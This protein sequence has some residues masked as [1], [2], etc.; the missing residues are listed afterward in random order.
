[1]GYGRRG[2]H[3]SLRPRGIATKAPWGQGGQAGNQRLLG[4]GVFREQTPLK[5][6]LP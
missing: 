1:M 2:L 3:L 6:K 5:E 4:P